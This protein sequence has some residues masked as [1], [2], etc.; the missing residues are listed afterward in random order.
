M[1]L[2]SSRTKKVVKVNLAQVSSLLGLCAILT[3][4]MIIL[5]NKTDI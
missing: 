2:V 1:I 3:F 5:K 4:I